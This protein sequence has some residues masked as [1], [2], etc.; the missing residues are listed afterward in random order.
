[1]AKEGRELRVSQLN[2][3]VLAWH[4]GQVE[5]QRRKREAA[6]LARL[7]A[8]RGSDMKVRRVCILI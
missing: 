1:M 2:R 4:E 5:E 8:L 7:Q 6:R 3:G